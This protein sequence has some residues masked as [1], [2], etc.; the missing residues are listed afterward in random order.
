MFIIR[1]GL[2]AGSVILAVAAIVVLPGLLGSG[3]DAPR[4]VAP[5]PVAAAPPPQPQVPPAPPPPVLRLVPES[6]PQGS[7]AMVVLIAQGV[8]AAVLQAPGLPP[9]PGFFLTN[10]RLIAFVG[11]PAAQ[12]PG[13]YAINVHWASGASQVTLKVTPQKFPEERL[14]VNDETNAVRLDPRQ[15]DDAKRLSVARMQSATIP[16][17][18]GPFIWPARGGITTNFGEMRFVNGV[19][20][21]FHTGIDV[22]APAGAPVTATNAGKVVLADRLVLTGNTV[23]IDHGLGIFSFYGHMQSLDVKPG[24]RVER[25]Q[26]LGKVGSTGFSTGPHLHWTMSVRDVPIDPRLF[27]DHTLLDR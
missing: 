5:A 9:S 10:D 19:F 8:Q 6:V 13:D 22:G 20:S 24:D 7:F 3:T 18:S 16:L 15:E 14:T 26:V 25:G 11:V 27:A 2:L 21:S 4:G 23:L 12:K 1:R 17:W